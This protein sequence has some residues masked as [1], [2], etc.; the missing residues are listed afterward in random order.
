MKGV[1]QGMSK[2]AQGSRFAGADITGDESGQAFL[3]GKSQATLNFLV[4][5]SREQVSGGD[6]SAEGGML[7]AIIIIEAGHGH[8][9]EVALDRVGPG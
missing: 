3:Q 4:T 7:E 1:V 8:A 2:G 6:R 9:P 5:V